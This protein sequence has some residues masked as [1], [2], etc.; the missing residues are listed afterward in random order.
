MLYQWTQRATCHTTSRR[1]VQAG[2]VRLIASVFEQADGR[3]AQR[4]VQHV[5]DGADRA[6]D[7][8]LDEFSG[9][10]HGDVLRPGIGMMDQPSGRPRVLAAARTCRACRSASVTMLECLVVVT[11]I[12]AARPH[13]VQLGGIV[14]TGDVSTSMFADRWNRRSP[15]LSLR[16]VTTPGSRTL[17]PVRCLFR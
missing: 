16:K 1:S 15:R 6:G 9:E 2:P 8:G 11:R 13:E 10:R 3:F 12:R 4:L 7:P 14:D 17:T 5:A